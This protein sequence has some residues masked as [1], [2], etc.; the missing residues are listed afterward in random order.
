[1]A[2]TKE[3]RAAYMRAW[4]AANPEKE[5]TYK[6]RPEAKAKARGYSAKWRAANP[7]KTREAVRRWR[8]NNYEKFYAKQKL[9]TKKWALA[10]PELVA[11]YQQRSRAGDRAFIVIPKDWRRLLERYRHCCAYCGE[12]CDKLER[13]HVIP[14]SRGGA[15]SI[16]NVLP[17][18]PACNGN[19][20][21]KLLIEWKAFKLA[22]LAKGA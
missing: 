8:K 12:K 13:E 14:L 18:C 7:D 22:K 15:H 9:R 17:A 10:H 6:S 5:K 11:E 1:M 16:G 4:R 20:Q 21:S 19:K 3:Q 2:Y